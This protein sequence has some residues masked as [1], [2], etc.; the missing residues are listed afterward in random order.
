[1]TQPHP[2]MSELLPMKPTEKNVKHGHARHSGIRRS[3]PTYTSWC[4]MHTRAR[5]P[6]RHNSYRYIGAGVTVCERWDSFENFLADMGE[7]PL[8][9][10]LE[11]NDNALG[12]FKGNCS[13]ATPTQQARNTRNN[14]LTFDSAVEVAL[15]RLSGESCRSIAV[16]F[17]I[18]ESLPREIVKGRTWKDALAT[19]LEIRNG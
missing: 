1:M 18:S 12:Y 4:S 6:R 19:A 11:R 16:A 2:V 13:W 17:G 10:S 8:G 9:T 5:N 7:R 3:T 15:R 14:V